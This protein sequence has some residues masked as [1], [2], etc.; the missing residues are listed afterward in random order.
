MKQFISFIRLNAIFILVA[1]ALTLS[2]KAEEIKYHDSWGPQGFQ[3]TQQKASSVEISYSV[4][5]FFMEEGDINGETM[6]LVKL[7]GVFL[8]NNEGAPDLPGHGRF[9]AIPEGA[10]A[11][12]T[13]KSARKESFQ[14]VNLAP[15][16]RIP[17]ETETGPLDYNK[18]MEI[19]SKN[20]FYPENPVNLSE[21]TEIRGVDAVMLGITPFQYNPVTKELIVYRDLKVEVTFEGGTGQYGDNRLRSRWW[22]PLLADMFLNYESLPKIDYSKSFQGNTKDIGCEYLIITPTN[23]EFLQW[24]DSIKQFRTMQGIQTDIMTVEEAGGN[25][26]NTLESF[27]NN[28]YN[29]WDIVPAAVLILGDY[30]T[31]SANSITSPIWDNY[32]VSDNIYADVTNNDM[33]DIVFARMTAQNAAQLEVMVTK[34]LNNERTPPTDPNFYNHPISALGF[35]TERWFQICSEAVAGFWEN[36]QGKETVRVNKTYIGNPTS[37]PWSTATNTS[38]VVNYF[39]PNGLGYIPS[40]PGQVNCTWNGSAQDVVNAINNGAFMLQH[41]DH[42][43]EQGWGEPA[44][45]NSNIPSLHNT[46]LVFVW[47]VNCLTGKYNYNS[48]V[49]AEKFHRYTYNGQNSGCLG[50]NAASEVSYSFVNDTYVWG[51]Y[52]NM[53]PNFMPD[54][55]TTPESRDVLPAFGS[56]AG[57]YYLQASNWPYNTSNK[58]VTYNLFHHHGDAFMT[59]Y[60]EVPQ[61]LTVTH[62]PILYAGVTSFDVTVN[63]GAFIAL[64]VNGEII[65]TAT[66]TGGPVSIDIP[67]QQPP[68]NMIVT[69]T[70]QNYY[71]Y[72]TAVEVIPPT[73]PYVVQESVELNDDSGNG[74]GVMETS[75]NI[76]ASLTVENV[77]V[78]DATNVSVTLE[79][80]DPYVTITDNTENYGTVAAGSTA[81]MTDGFAWDV[82]NNIP[83]MHMVIFDVVATDGTDTWTTS[84]GVEGHGPELVVGDLIIDDS[85]GNNNG[86]L[87]PGETADLIIETY[88]DGSYHALSPLG[89]L[90][91]SNSYVTITSSSYNFNII[92]FGQMEEAV[93]TISVSD[94]APIGTPISIN[95]G[96]VSGGYSVQEVFGAT[97]GLILED[98]ETG[99]MSQYDW[100]TGGSSNWNVVSTGAYEGTYCAKSGT[101][102]NNA[103][104]WI[105]L[106]YEVSSANVISF[107]YKVSS[108][109]TYDFLR[110]YIDNNEQDAWSGEVGW[111]EAS[112]D[113]GPGVHTFKWE[114]DKDYSVSSGS[115]CG[116]ID[117]IIL[118]PPPTTTAFAGQDDITCGATDY[119]C[120]GGATLYNLLNWT[121]S[122]SGSFDDASILSPVYTPSAQDVEDGSV[123]LSITAYATGYQVTDD[124]T[125]TL[126]AEPVAFAGEDSEACSNAEF[127]L[128]EATAEN[129]SEIMWSTTGDGTFADDQV[130]NTTYMPGSDDI[131][132]GSVTLTLTAMSAGACDNHADQIL[133]TI[134]E[135]PTA[136]AGSVTTICS[137]GSTI[138]AD[139]NATNYGELMWSTSGDGTFDDYTL[140]NPAYTPG[141]NDIANGSAELTLTALGMGNCNEETA[142]VNVQINLAAT[143]FAGDDS[144]IASDETY[145]IDDASAADYNTL[146]WSTDGDGTFD[147]N[148]AINPVYTPGSNDITEQE[149]TLTLTAYG[150]DPCGE[151][152]DDMVLAINPTGIGDQASGTKLGIY[153]NP[154]SGQ[155]TISL[156]GINEDEIS[157]RIYNAI[158]GEVFTKENI[159]VSGSLREVIDLDT[160]QGVYYIRVEGDQLL[161]NQKMI[162]KK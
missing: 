66:S 40:T 20:A 1:S 32:C 129:A 57:K 132:N 28:A 4:N 35:Q 8:S 54:Y 47:S 123:V 60:S 46:D 44:F 157:L 151:T 86:R 73:G 30:G 67:A 152:S 92:P 104:T 36:A 98:W 61:N 156:E 83:D 136:Y 106:E 23:P 135:G 70:K 122:G 147:D 55:G 84:F 110:F 3:L 154:N 13:I 121:T 125:L 68:D 33:P 134:V 85:D 50:I 21:I 26:V 102:G 130:L 108:E 146:M 161:I 14:N 87:D 74:N 133:L 149:V 141:S 37:D 31:N 12:V 97:I 7:P 64:T 51:A 58:E 49:F 43:F 81:T 39:G 69:I 18:N 41:R 144:A 155:F 112:Y 17:W 103:S 109:N 88:N 16:A 62:N 153:P 105:E 137:D 56:A 79:T 59:V 6:D 25:N 101:I 118:P 89:S 114:Y 24:A 11:I 120:N 158:G 38:T 148:S 22:D 111:S 63:E 2:L 48:E 77:G 91:I 75:E 82:A 160:E 99:D 113:V 162:I 138:L 80:T 65:G 124:M 5:S 115:D 71:R 150:N 95:Y 45:T 42:G 140:M 116:W 53:W 107:M 139:A 131:T 119:Q 117:Y 143:A 29:S 27:F 19:Y 126:D 94:Q 159:Q 100:T 9:L 15:A 93:F 78:E 76:M 145:T 34:F 72:S 142:S 128:S 96:V 90:S 127:E 10:N 52:D